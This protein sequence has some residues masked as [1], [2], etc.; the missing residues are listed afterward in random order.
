M[1]HVV[2]VVVVTLVVGIAV[3]SAGPSSSVP[4]GTISLTITALSGP[5]CPVQ[6]DPP[7]TGC[8]PRPVAGATVKVVDEQ[9]RSIE[10]RTDAAGNANFMLEVGRYDIEANPVE[11]LMGTPDAIQVDLVDDQAV[12]LSYDTGIR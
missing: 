6:Q 2:I 4:T 7:Q 9:G 3:R 12:T 10:A 1:K 8:E 5:T 11:G